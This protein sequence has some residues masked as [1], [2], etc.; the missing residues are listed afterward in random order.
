MRSVAR[1]GIVVNHL[2]ENIDLFSAIALKMTGG[3]GGRSER[4]CLVGAIALT[5]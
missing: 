5:R 2:V 3:H 4:T 1:L